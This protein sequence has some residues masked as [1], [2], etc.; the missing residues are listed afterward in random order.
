MSAD[1][2]DITIASRPDEMSSIVSC[3]GS[4]TFKIAFLLFIL[5]III[6]SDVFVDGVLAVSGK[7]YTD[8]RYPTTQGVMAQGV[9]LALC[10][11][12]IHTLATCGYI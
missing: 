1:S 10:Y 12:L 5:F 8:G 4:N 11:I 6:S 2:E 9:I 3:I 7:K